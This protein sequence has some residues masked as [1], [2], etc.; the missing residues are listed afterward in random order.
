MLRASMIKSQI[1][2]IG[3]LKLNSLNNISGPTLCDVASQYDQ[4]P[5]IWYR[6][7]QVKLILTFQAPPS[8]M[9]R[10]SMIKS[11]MSDIESLKLNSF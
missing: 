5:D 4:V 2:E 8:V 6:I 7:S 1:S 3:S 9:L 10:T 11:Q